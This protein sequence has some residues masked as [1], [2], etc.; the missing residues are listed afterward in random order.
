MEIT[1]DKII[2]YLKKGHLAISE[3]SDEEEE[4]MFDFLVKKGLMTLSVNGIAL[5]N[6]E[7]Q[8]FIRSAYYFNPVPLS[9]FDWKMNII[10]QLKAGKAILKGD[11]DLQEQAIS[12][13]KQDGIV[14]QVGR[15]YEKTL[16]SKGRQFVASGLPYNDFLYGGSK[17]LSISIEPIVNAPIED[18]KVSILKYLM[19]TKTKIVVLIIPNNEKVNDRLF[20]LAESELKESGFIRNTTNAGW[21]ITESGENYLTRHEFGIKKEEKP[22]ISIGQIGNNITNSRIAHSDLS[23]DAL[24]NSITPPSIPHRK[25]TNKNI[26]KLIL[27][28]IV[29]NIWTFILFVFIGIAIWYFTTYD[30]IFQHK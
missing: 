15:S 29:S 24:I 14:E 9:V 11:G 17:P 13:L 27:N 28:W 19:G 1:Q 16:T 20:K 7:G 21:I 22:F 8:A 26:G 25:Q 10:E 6:N 30:P 23:T 5:L 3:S 12:E 2:Q 18:I 4:F